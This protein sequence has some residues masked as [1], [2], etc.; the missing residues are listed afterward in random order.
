[1]HYNRLLSLC[2]VNPSVQPLDILIFTLRD[3]ESYRL[4]WLPS[5]PT[6]GSQIYVPDRELQP[7]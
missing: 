6:A 1:M 2:Y 3:V 4:A 7:S 5:A